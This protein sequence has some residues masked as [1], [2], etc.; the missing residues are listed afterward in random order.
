VAKWCT[1]CQDVTNFFVL[2]VIVPTLFQLRQHEWL[3]LRPFVPSVPTQLPQDMHISTVCCH[4][5]TDKP[6]SCVLE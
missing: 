5:L 2:V 1:C 4:E 3:S 6:E